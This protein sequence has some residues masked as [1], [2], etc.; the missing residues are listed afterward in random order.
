MINGMW[1]RVKGV[2]EKILEFGLNV[3]LRSVFFKM[4][5]FLDPVSSIQ[6]PASRIKSIPFPNF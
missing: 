6:Y 3:L 5:E 2:R 4:T 1:Y